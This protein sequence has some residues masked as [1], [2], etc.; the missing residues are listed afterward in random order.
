MVRNGRTLVVGAMLLLLV[1]MSL[2]Q[3]DLQSMT[4]GNLIIS[5]IAALKSTNINRA[6]LCIPNG[7][8]APF[9]AHYAQR[10]FGL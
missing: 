8:V 7:G 10:L 4:K 3:F 5:D 6:S 2:P 9:S 1:L